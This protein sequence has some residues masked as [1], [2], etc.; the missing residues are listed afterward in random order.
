MSLSL[1]IVQGSATDWPL[2]A[3]NRG[4]Q[5]QPVYASGDT[6]MAS[7]WSGDTTTV[8]FSPT[9]AWYTAGSTQ[10]G[11]G[12]GQVLVSPTAA[13]SATLAQ[14]GT[15][16]LEV[17]WTQAGGGKTACIARAT[18]TCLPAPGTGIPAQ[19][20]LIGGWTG[21]TYALYTDMLEYA[22]FVRMIQSQDTDQEGF[23]AQLLRS[24]QWLDWVII[25]NYRGASVGLF[26]EHSTLAFVFG[27]GVGW[28]RSL[29]PSPSLITYLAANDL[30]LRP[31]IVTASA[32]KAIAEVCR[33]QIG[34]A[35][36]WASQ[37]PY[38]DALA[39]REVIGTTAEIDLN[40]D[41]VGELFIS[42][43]ACNPLAT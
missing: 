30:L 22:P 18:I 16:G 21:T 24:R 34:I 15:Y 13:Q 2:Q 35:N 14:N 3:Q 42:L 12:Q 39:E 43:G 8:L 36:Q 4:G 33:A 41:G 29:G 11:Y 28:R 17:W 6:L 38:W 37:A 25:N 7:V 31:Q 32:Y 10:T 1:T 26:E 19:R 27:G 9:V 40:A 20:G 23:A 5:S